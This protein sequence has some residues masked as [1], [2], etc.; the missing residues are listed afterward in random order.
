MNNKMYEK[1]ISSNLI[2]DYKNKIFI[3]KDIDFNKFIIG[4]KNMY[5]YRNISN[6][7]KNDYSVF[8]KMFYNHEIIDRKNMEIINLKVPLF[9]ALEV[10]KIFTE[11]G[12][13]YK[14][15]YYISL[16]ESIYNNTWI[17]N[18]E[19]KPHQETDIFKLSEFSYTLKDYQLEF[20]KKYSEL[21]SIY[22]LEGYILSFEQG[23]GKTFTAICLAE[24]LNKEQIV[25]V[26]PNSLKENWAYEIKMYYKKYY[27]DEIA[28][29]K[30]IYIHNSPKF[31]KSKNP[32]FY[33]VNQESIDKIFNKVSV[34]KNT[35][36]I[37][38]ESHNFRNMDSN[39]VKKLI[40]LKELLKCK[41]NLIMSGTPIKATPNEIVPALRMI[42][43]YFT[44]EL[45]EIYINTFKGSSEKISSIV[46]E[47]F[48]RIIYRKTK[49]QVLKLPNKIVED[50]K[51]TI[52]E[53]ERYSVK[54]LKSEIKNEYNKEI[55]KKLKQIK[56]LKSE[57]DH[58]VIS[59][60]SKDL[61]ITR[62]YL[63]Y[64]Y[65]FANPKEDNEDIHEHRRDNYKNFLKDNVYPNI[66]NIKI[67][68]KL[69]E[70]VTNYLH[71]IEQCVGV[72]V[73]RVLP[74]AK[75][76]CFKE[77]FDSNIKYFIKTIKE[78]P[79]KTII[80]TPFV[81]VANHINEQLNKKGI[82]CIKIIGETKNRMDM[83]NNF[84]NL[85]KIQVLVATTQTL[86]TGVT[87]V[88]A[89]QMFFFGTPYR[90]ADFEQACDRIH[91][92]GQTTDVNIY[93][94]LLDSE[95]KNITDRINEIM[96]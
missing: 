35:M 31:D 52:P 45:A 94:V 29:E 40:Q 58:I 68:S 96:T 81:E 90:D 55:N 17:S 83:I 32:K 21:K 69:K 85:D 15:P 43:P 20:V 49:D 42:D 14:L 7:F 63:D 26:C 95:Y 84:K 11:Y 50:I 65:N 25:I 88:E 47:R 59:Y 71:M 39:R 67:E 2:I 3:I 76:N 48:S 86:S 38:D 54:F 8:S 75:I 16:A 36:I 92:I 61:N 28:W 10:Y 9:F 12:K 22:D 1:Q 18:Y 30:D 64:I 57:F 53:P 91:R 5:S 46:K 89:N 34:N 80:F 4:L 79:K 44:D 73:G 23:L 66:N 72:A 60:S 77:L 19:N 70:L 33:I 27:D 87:L 62:D 13:F 78:N 51:L 93:V 74:D 6:L 82:G 41:D 24:C 37:L 56:E